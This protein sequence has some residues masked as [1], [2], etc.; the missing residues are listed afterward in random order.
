MLL[1]RIITMDVTDARSSRYAQSNWW[2]L[3]LPIWSRKST[4]RPSN[5]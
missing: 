3:E 4:M 5:N 2:W 1:E